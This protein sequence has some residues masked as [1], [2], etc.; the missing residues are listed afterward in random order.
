MLITATLPA[1]LRMTVR[2]I[3]GQAESGVT[4]TLASERVAV[5]CPV[6]RVSTS[7]VHSRYRRTLA[8][9]PWQGLAVRLSLETRR[10][11]CDATSCP[12]LIFAEPFPGLAPAR[13]R[14]T[15]RLTALY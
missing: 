4:I 14:R 8:D 1:D 10:F 9:L 11:F 15:A 13:S 12:R 7:R 5:A 2:A 6:C 3:E